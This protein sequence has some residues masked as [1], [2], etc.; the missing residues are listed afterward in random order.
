MLKHDPSWPVGARRRR[1]SPNTEIDPPRPSS[2]IKGRRS[3]G[4]LLFRR[5]IGD[6]KSENGNRLIRFNHGVNFPQYSTPYNNQISAQLCNFLRLLATESTTG[7][8]LRR[9]SYSTGSSVYLS[10]SARILPPHPRQASLDD[11]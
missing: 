6:K 1:Q 4:E 8:G 10:Y 11:R 3:L 5:P 9:L 7:V 2:E